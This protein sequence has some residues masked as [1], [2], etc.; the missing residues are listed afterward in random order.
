MESSQ[1][2]A[3]ATSGATQ[4]MGATLIAGVAGYVVTWLVYRVVGPAP[5]ALFA[6]FW[7]ALYLVV[8]A[9]SGIQ[10]EITR[11][12]NPIE[13]GSR[14]RAS[15]SRT[16][17]IVAAAATAVAVI[18]SAPLWV[19][20]VFP[21]EGWALVWP[22]AV[23]AASYVLVATLSGSLY[24]VSQWRSLALMIAV[25]GVLRLALVGSIL[26][27]TNSIVALAW[28]ATLPFPLAIMLLWPFIRRTF[29]GR[30]DIDVGI[31]TL[32]WN[33]GR[34]VLASVSTAVLVSGF[35]LLLGVTS[36]GTEAALVGELVFTLTLTRAPL[37]VTVMALQSYLI[38]QFRALQ[39]GWPTL[40]AKVLG[41]IGIGGVALAL[42]G[43]WLGPA[44]FEL[45]SATPITVEGTFIAV[46]VASSALIGALS[47]SGSAVLAHGQHVVYSAGW[48][49]A[50]VA[51][52][53]IMA[54][55]GMDLQA[56]I[57]TATLVAPCVGL[58]LHAAWLLHR[59]RSHD[60]EGVRE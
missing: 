24:G 14:V 48:V 58:L 54:L 18:A 36:R 1:P 33:V 2:R 23:G 47:V 4:I 40:F 32:T 46:M 3:R 7:A 50:A 44:V 13:A 17:A 42:A 11:A 29:V 59:H 39:T 45:V 57:I 10:Q 9:L 35:P 26:A 12:T 5:Y 27:T 21:A 53:V 15:R 8:G 34:T 22:L 31:R 41:V 25:D 38:V 6:V 16:F 60:S 52:V 37:V 49:A 20:A 56:R 43:W 51:T 28:A 19:E 30:S 55:P